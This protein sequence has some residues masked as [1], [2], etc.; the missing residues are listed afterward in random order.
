MSVFWLATGFTRR[1]L[2][3]GRRKRRRQ[4]AF[5]I[6]RLCIQSPWRKCGPADVTTNLAPS[7]T[8][9]DR[10]RIDTMDP[11]RFLL[12][13]LGNSITSGTFVDTKFYVFSRREASGCV[14]SPRALY[15]NSGVLN[16]VPYFSSCGH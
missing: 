15:C 2:P 6:G 10:V 8:L 16:T 11:P 3:G 1:R 4:I 5:R 13:A 12:D 9:Q 7:H 14:G